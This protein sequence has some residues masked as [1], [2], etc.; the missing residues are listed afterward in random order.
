[1]QL[2]RREALI[3]SGG[4][5]LGTTPVFA[6]AGRP[7]DFGWI[8]DPEI[9]AEWLRKQDR[10]YFADHAAEIAGSGRG[11]QALLVPY[12][13]KASGQKYFPSI[14]D[15]GDCTSHA[16]A[17][18]VNILTGVQIV[19]HG[20]PERWVAP[21]ATEPIHAGA[22]VEIGGSKIKS[23]RDGA[24]VS[25]AG[26]WVQQYGVLLRQKY[27]DIDLTTYNPSLARQWGSRYVGV[28]DSL[29]AIAKEHPVKTIKVTTSWSEARD[30]IFNGYPVVIGSTIG[31]NSKSDSDGFL[32]PGP[33]WWH[34]L[35]LAGID[36][37]SK[38]PG[39][40]ILNWWAPSW[41]SGPKHKLGTPTSAFWADA[42]VIDNMLSQGDSIALS[43]YVGYKR[44]PLNYMLIPR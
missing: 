18:G 44:Q 6:G 1:M 39:G 26:D 30:L 40:L 28:P 11:Q 13:E 34:A 10:P 19:M 29:E 15:I 33:T 23:R 41:T 16:M 42:D 7:R 12:L 14:Q 9:R 38:R 43:N 27:G 2:S 17:M 25:W 20:R 32:S 5:L 31:F 36:D 24:C 8:P 3:L 37:K 22:R 4:L 21:A 35:L